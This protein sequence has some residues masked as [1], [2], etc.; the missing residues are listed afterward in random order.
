MFDNIGGKI[1]ALAKIMCWV[2]IIGFVI[3]AMITFVNASEAGSY[4]SGSLI[5]LG[6][7]FLIIGPLVSWVFS[8]FMYGFGELIETNCEIAHNTSKRV[9]REYFE[10]TVN[11]KGNSGTAS[12]TAMNPDTSVHAWL[13]TCEMCKRQNVYLTSVKIP[14]ESGTECKNVCAECAGKYAGTADGK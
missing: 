1:K 14:N 10:T 13:G 2:G 12:R 11:Q 4:L 5:V 3:L 9:L 6:F 8:F 7:V